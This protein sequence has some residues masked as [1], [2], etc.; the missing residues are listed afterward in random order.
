VNVMLADVNWLLSA[1]AQSSAA[2]IAI[3]GGLL[4]SRYVALHAEQQGA[5]RRVEDLQRREKEATNAL[6]DARID[7]DMYYI[8]DALD[9]TAVFQEI[10]E[11]Q[12]EPTVDG[13][14]DAID[15]DGA[16]LNRELLSVEL[17]SMTADMKSAVSA[18]YELVPL[19]TEQ[20]DWTTFR[21]AHSLEVGHRNLWEWVY[22]KICDERKR[23][24]KRAAM[25]ARKN[26]PYANLFGLSEPP[27][28][29]SLLGLSSPEI[30]AANRMIRDRREMARVDALEARIG[31]F[32]A[33]LLAL[34]QERRLAQETYQA[35]RQPEGFVL[36]LQVLTFLA[37][38]GM[39]VPVVIMGFA[40]LTISG[41]ARAAVVVLFFLGVSLLLRFLF[42][43]AAFLREGGRE[44]LPHHLAGLFRR[45]PKSFGQDD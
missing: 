30:I 39:G 33:E 26:S 32:E 2:L 8:D 25:E 44:S 21:R 42:V 5:Q 34:S 14:L 43:Y 1:L 15:D 35:T 19:S 40:P 27:D 9:D 23:G 4:V 37:I 22:N 31:A 7:L 3:V 16:N 45:G 38:V 24:A 20:D 29:T 28:Y 13:V 11:R 41:Y 17:L 18:M 36:A 12:L 10:F 6:A